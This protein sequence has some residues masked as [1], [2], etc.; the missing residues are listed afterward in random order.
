MGRSSM[1]QPDQKE[2]KLQSLQKKDQYD[3]KQVPRLAFSLLSLLGRLLLIGV[4]NSLLE[5]HPMK[6]K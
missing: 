4:Q 3:V 5:Y 6:I 1:V 2:L